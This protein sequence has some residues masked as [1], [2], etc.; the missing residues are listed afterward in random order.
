MI[1][2]AED[3]F[4]MPVGH[5]YVFFREMFIE[6]LCPFLKV[7]GVFWRRAL[8]ILEINPYQIRGLQTLGPILQVARGLSPK[9]LC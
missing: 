9:S 5:L 6:I 8:H 1:S 3:F 2:D 7:I 4:H